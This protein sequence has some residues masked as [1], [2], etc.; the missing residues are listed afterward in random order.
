M[1]IRQ[2]NLFII[3]LLLGFTPREDV[4]R[5]TLTV[6]A[7]GSGDYRTVQAAFAAATSNTTIF[8]K[9][10]T[11][12]EKLQLDSTK[13]TISPWSATTPATTILTYDDHPGMVAPNGDMLH[14]HPQLL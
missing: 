7:D 5:N 9:A 1:V 3:F 2:V 12:R 13:E 8:V 14:Q 4:P 11:Y 6:A 10:G